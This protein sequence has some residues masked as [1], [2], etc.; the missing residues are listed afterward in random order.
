MASWDSLGGWGTLDHVGA[1][2]PM[3]WLWLGLDWRLAIELT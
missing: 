3:A 1:L 2:K